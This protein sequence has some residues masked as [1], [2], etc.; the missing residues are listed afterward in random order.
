MTPRQTMECVE[1]YNDLCP[2]EAKFKSRNILVGFISHLALKLHHKLQDKYRSESKGATRLA[3]T[4]I[5]LD[6]VRQT[7][8]AD[9]L[10]PNNLLAEEKY[11][12]YFWH[13]VE[14]EV[15][16]LRLLLLVKKVPID[17]AW[18]DI[19]LVADKFIQL[20]D[21]K[22]EYSFDRGIIDLLIENDQ[23]QTSF[24]D[25]Q[26]STPSILKTTNESHIESYLPKPSNL[27]LPEEELYDS[28]G[29]RSVKMKKISSLHE[30]II[31]MN[32]SRTKKRSSN[33]DIQYSPTSN[34]TGPK[35][36]QTRIDDF[37]KKRTIQNN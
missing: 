13:E 15:L 23:A 37:F 36:R 6:D 26:Q 14:L 18:Q 25:P 21:T 20:K 27:I 24:Y 5:D 30:K 29:E 7:I 4:Y 33:V 17:T 22:Y 19:R 3:M 16:K 11:I 34:L 31:K 1:V 12:S 10:T 32:S 9:P 28:F 2:N 8:Y 35:L